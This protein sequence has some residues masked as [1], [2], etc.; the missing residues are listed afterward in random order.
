MLIM[1]ARAAMA[2]SCSGFTIGQIG[3]IM[4]NARPYPP[5]LPRCSRRNAGTSITVT[6][7]EVE[8]RLARLQSQTGQKLSAPRQA[9]PT[10]FELCERGGRR[11]RQGTLTKETAN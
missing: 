1:C 8:Q 11:Y 9:N 5:P 7:N 10:L 3:G 2:P 4:G 6:D